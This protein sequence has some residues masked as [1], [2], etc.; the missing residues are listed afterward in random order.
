MFA[1]FHITPSLAFLGDFTTLIY[2]ANNEY[3]PNVI[4]LVVSSLCA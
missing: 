3:V 2:K 1:C 4:L